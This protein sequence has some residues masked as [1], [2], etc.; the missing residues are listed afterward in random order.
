MDGWDDDDDDEFFVDDLGGRE[1][2][3]SDPEPNDSRGPPEPARNTAEIAN[4][5]NASDGFLEDGWGD[6]ED[7]DDQPEFGEDW[8]EVDAA[9]TA[10]NGN[11]LIAATSTWE[12]P[13]AATTTLHPSSFPTTS[14]TTPPQPPI[15]IAP[16]P[17]IEQ[18]P[19][20][21][22]YYCATLE[23]Y[24]L[25]DLPNIAPSLTALLEAEYNTVE[26]ALELHEYYSSRP[27]LAEY[28]IQK[29][30]PRMEYAI[31]TSS[32]ES[33]TATE[34]FASSA[35]GS[36]NNTNTNTDPT[37][38]YGITDKAWIAQRFR[39]EESL[40]APQPNHHPPC[41]LAARC[42][43]QSLLADLLQVLTG[44][45][46]LVRPQYHAATVA[47]HCRFVLP[48]NPMDWVHVQATLEVS[49]PLEQQRGRWTVAIVPIEVHFDFGQHHGAIEQPP[50][51]EFRLGTVTR[52][53]SRQ[54]A[55]WHEN[56]QDCARLLGLLHCH[57]EEGNENENSD[58]YKQ[59]QQQQQSLNFRDAF[60][61]SSQSLWQSNAVVGMKSAWDDL[62]A[63][64]G[65]GH[66]W[67][68]LPTLL[69]PDASVWEAVARDEEMERQQQHRS[70]HYGHYPQHQPDGGKKLTGLVQNPQQ[71]RPPPPLPQ[72]QQQQQ[73]HRPTSILGGLV[74][75]LAKSVALPE[76]D[77]TLYQ[78]WNNAALSTSSHDVPNRPTLY[79]RNPDIPLAKPGVG[80][81]APLLRSVKPTTKSRP[82]NKEKTSSLKLPISRLYNV[83][84]P[85]L[86]QKSSV[87]SM[88]NVS[89]V[90]APPLHYRQQQEMSQTDLQPSDP[91]N[92]WGDDSDIDDQEWNVEHGGD[93]KLPQESASGT[94]IL[95]TH[96]IH[97]PN[98]SDNDRSH[99]DD[100]WVYDCETDII[101]T[102]KRWVN[103]TP[104]PRTL[105][106]C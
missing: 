94:S 88:P 22:E 21:T 39:R 73:Q 4:A 25:T 59:Q 36:T 40:N 15:P 55:D 64:T 56:L 23:A 8:K 42:A 44:P 53:A 81:A 100:E 68:Q 2:N 103:P 37:Q 34:T 6:D 80:G 29:E 14:T 84:T 65:L 38:R 13:L 99:I 1:A 52:V 24:L 43:N 50:R 28:T 12:K 85:P 67:N 75:S 66:K 63:A 11:R 90:S 87:T 79:N 60:L 45:D 9:G 95:V 7:N 17:S 71:P 104:G 57:D 92:G 105:A 30:L 76:E 47:T 19:F 54:D 33:A 93:S 83:K 86:V 58:E 77:A 70:D 98:Q 102:R 96:P 69:L 48:D 35:S 41:S 18:H 3:A 31:L 82:A 26:K 51:V 78:D 89:N 27:A 20:S 74:R 46:R 32:A 49:L 101:P 16:P 106:P 62:N 97:K 5:A 61:Q 91:A 72:Q 10:T